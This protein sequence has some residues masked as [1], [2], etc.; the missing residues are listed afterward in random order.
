MEKM[1]GLETELPSGHAFKV[2]QGLSHKPGTA[3]GHLL[4][5]IEKTGAHFMLHRI[6]AHR[7]IS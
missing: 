2:H 4:I 3:A 5:Q 1:N 7:F 6:G